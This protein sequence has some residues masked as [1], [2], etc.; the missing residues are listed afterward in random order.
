MDD[1]KITCFISL[2]Q[3]LNYS[4]TAGA[5]FMTQQAVSKSIAAM[6]KELGIIL[7]QRNTRAVKI[8]PEGEKLYSVLSRLYQEY[9]NTIIEL[10]NQQRLH[11]LHVGYQNFMNIHKELHASLLKLKGEYPEITLEGNRYCPP[12]LNSLLNNK[13]LDM[14]AIYERFLYATEDYNTAC[15]CEVPQMFMVSKEYQ[16]AAA[17]GTADSLLAGPFIIDRFDGE[18]T[19]EFNKRVEMEY[20]RWGFKGAE[21]IVVPDRDSAYTYAELG[22]GVVVGTNLSI[23]SSSRALVSVYTGISEKLLIVW[24]KRDDIS[25]IEKFAG[26]FKSEFDA[27]HESAGLQS[28]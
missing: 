23:M 13:V 5:V 9:Q 24:R 25:V 15:L 19:Q 12:V 2:A 28:L 11:T 18:S 27:R 20:S 3:T 1:T 26:L 7:F 16:A 10:K 22:R 6:E 8:T 4:Q 21:I 14:I 17:G